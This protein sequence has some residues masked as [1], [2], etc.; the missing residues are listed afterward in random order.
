MKKYSLFPILI[1][2]IVFVVSYHW[3]SNIIARAQTPNECVEL[4]YHRTMICEWPV[5]NFTNYTAGEGD[6]VLAGKV[7]HNNS[8]NG[9]YFRLNGYLINNGSCTMLVVESAVACS[10]PIIR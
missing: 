3:T 9:R 7:P 10:S 2:L 1:F 6:V 8:W 4:T 5:G